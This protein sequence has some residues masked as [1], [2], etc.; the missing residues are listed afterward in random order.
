MKVLAS[1]VIRSTHRGDSHG[2]LYIVDTDRGTY[3]QVLSWDY[4]KI[5]WEGKGGD[6]GLRGLIFHKDRLFA[7]GANELFEF[8]K[9]FELIDQHTH[10]L[11]DGTHELAIHND[12]IYN[13]SNCY[14][15]IL[16]FDLASKQWTT[17]FQHIKTRMPIVFNLYDN[18]PIPRVDTL[19]LDSV[20]I[21][22]DWLYYAGSTTEHL[23]GI[24]I[25]TGMSAEPILLY[26][27]NTHNAQFWK[28]GIVFNRSLESDTCY[29]VGNNLVRHWPTPKCDR[30]LIT[31]AGLP[32]DHARAEYTRG[33]VVGEHSL[34]I[35]TSPAC[36]HEFI[37]SREAPISTVRLTHDI[38]NSICG[39]TKYEW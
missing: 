31:N 5:R 12:C 21:R 15:A 7:A 29:Q 17:G 36:I 33:M 37:L 3:E 32:A 18:P 22:D 28:D 39:M 23:Y 11:L 2:G 19:H 1:S 8:N 25:I 4:E 24:H 20:T 38:R 16:C 9:D 34:C 6:R 14:D 26:H 27:K 35:G 10:P 13:I 30:S